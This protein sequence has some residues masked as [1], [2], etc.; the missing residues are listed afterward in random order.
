MMFAGG[1]VMVALLILR[2]TFYWWPLHPIGFAGFGLE[3]GMWFSFLLGWLFKRTALTYG[4]GEFSQKVNPFFY[5]L[6]IGQFAMAGFWALV[7]VCGQGVS[8]QGNILPACGF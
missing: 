1:I 6:I 3:W 7:G 5:G 2:S 8:V 4:G